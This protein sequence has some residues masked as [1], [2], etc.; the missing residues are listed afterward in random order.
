MAEVDGDM[1]MAWGRWGIGRLVPVDKNGLTGPATS[2]QQ[3]IRRRGPGHGCAGK[4]IQFN[5]PR[6]SVK[7]AGSSNRSTQ[8]FI[9]FPVQVFTIDHGMCFPA[10]LASAFSALDAATIAG[11]LGRRRH[12]R[13]QMPV[14]NLSPGPI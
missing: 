8:Q 9:T 11:L 3:W 1:E 14:Q 10:H 2:T 7:F 5:G 12:P 6:P 4:R 13:V